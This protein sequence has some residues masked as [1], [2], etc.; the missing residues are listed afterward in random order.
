[1]TINVGMSI[2]SAQVADSA[3]IASL[4]EAA[5]RHTYA[6][7]AQAAVY[8]AVITQTCTVNAV[9]ESILRAASD[10][11]GHFLVGTEDVVVRGFLDFGTDDD[12]I[13]ELRRLYT[14]VGYTGR[15]IGAALL[16]ELERR[17]PAATG[18]RAIVHARNEGG[19][20]FWVRHGFTI[21]GELDTR[22]HFTAHR[23]LAF[24]SPSENEP[25]LVLRRLTAAVAR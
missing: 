19:L 11:N 16:A 23:G 15:G 9:A 18:Y 7:I 10:P 13:L 5:V 8:E 22:Q 6:P 2:R 21:D 17:L 4:A 12:G 14:Q 1:V 3:A 20:R 24:E 25:S